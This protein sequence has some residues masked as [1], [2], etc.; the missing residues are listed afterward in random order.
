V[1]PTLYGL[2]AA[3]EILQPLFVKRQTARMVNLWN[4]DK[5][6]ETDT[7]DKEKRKDAYV[8]LKVP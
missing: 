7:A 6:D 3:T 8:R 1:D 5:A 4:P 2:D